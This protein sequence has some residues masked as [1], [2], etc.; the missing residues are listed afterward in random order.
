[1]MNDR[2]DVGYMTGPKLRAARRSKNINLSQSAFGLIVCGTDS[3]KIAQEM[4][5]RYETGVK[6]I[7]Y[8]M[9]IAVRYMV[10][11]GLPV[12]VIE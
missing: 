4:I 3:P 5:S 10:A 7:P 9:S 12:P 8:P 1:M 11:Y 6:P 2:I